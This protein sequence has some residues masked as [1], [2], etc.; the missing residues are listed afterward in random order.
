MPSSGRLRRVAVVRTDVSEERSAS[1]IRVTR[2]GELGTILAV[3]SNRRTLRRNLKFYTAIS[4]HTHL[5]FYSSAENCQ[6][7]CYPHKS[8]SWFSHPKTHLL[9]SIAVFRLSLSVPRRRRDGGHLQMGHVV[10]ATKRMSIHS[11]HKLLVTR[12]SEYQLCAPLSRV[13]GW[14]VLPRVSG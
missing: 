4:S 12:L 10:I 14:K 9:T 5:L 11:T 7:Y 13:F 1:I 3:T 6:L 2:I 8:L